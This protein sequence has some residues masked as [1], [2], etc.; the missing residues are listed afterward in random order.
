MEVWGGESTLQM[1]EAKNH[2]GIHASACNFSYCL[3]TGTPPTPP[4]LLKAGT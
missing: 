2:Y 4:I 1:D 3:G